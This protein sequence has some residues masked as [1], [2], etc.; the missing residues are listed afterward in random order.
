MD[1]VDTYLQFEW[2]WFVQIMLAL[3][4]SGVIGAE[5]QKHGRP[6]GIRTHML[7][8]L[9]ATM[10]TIVSDS[11]NQGAAGADAVLRVD[12]GRV[13]AGIVT[14]IGFLGAGAILRM[15]DLVRGLTTA[16]GIWFVAG[17]GIAIGSGMLLFSGLSTVIALVVLHVVHTF[18]RHIKVSHYRRLELLG[19]G[20]AQQLQQDLEP[21]LTEFGLTIMELEVECL[22]AEGIVKLGYNMRYQG[23][24]RSVAV[25]DRVSNLERVERCRWGAL[26][27]RTIL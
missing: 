23:A 7:V 12:P 6:A 18:D 15:G 2:I 1:F 9:A 3:L 4:L 10:L 21:V 17:L 22:P 11:Y 8:C 14:G 16:A 24:R 20:T 13:A 26:T 25:A 27:E 5:R 19:K